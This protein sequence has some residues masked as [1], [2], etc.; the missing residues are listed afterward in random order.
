M[1]GEGLATGSRVRVDGLKAK[2]ELNGS[3]ATVVGLN[4][5][6]GRYNVMIDDRREA[7]ALKLEALSLAEEF[8][9]I[10]L[11]A[12]VRLAGLDKKPDGTS[13]DKAL[14]GLLATV[15]S[16]SGETCTVEVDDM[17]DEKHVRQRLALK[18]ESLALAEEAPSSKP[19]KADDGSRQVVVT[20]GKVSLKLTLTE[21][22]MRKTVADAVIKPFLKAYSKKVGSEV[23]IAEVRQVTIDSDGQ[24]ELQVLT[25]IHIFTT[26][27]ALR[28]LEGDIDIEILLKGDGT[29]AGEAPKAPPKK[30]PSA[31]PDEVYHLPSAQPN[32]PRTLT[33]KTAPKHLLSISLSIPLHRSCPSTRG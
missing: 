19:A 4:E 14:N 6:T 8:G 22:Q 11:G 16:F 10:T 5:D 20:C 23:G 25:D 29:A 21:K 31:V 32:L 13:Y 27:Q 3:Y 17:L 7:L 9:R 2:P 15:I 12:K 24:R 18:P 28:K 33:G 30:A 1:R 26:E